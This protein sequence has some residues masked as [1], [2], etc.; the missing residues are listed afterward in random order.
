VDQVIHPGSS[1]PTDPRRGALLG[2]EIAYA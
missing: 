2:P 1:C